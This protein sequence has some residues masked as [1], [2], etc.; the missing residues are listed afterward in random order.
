MVQ[1]SKSKIRGKINTEEDEK[2]I[3]RIANN[4]A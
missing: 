3:D 4:F 2:I 1:A